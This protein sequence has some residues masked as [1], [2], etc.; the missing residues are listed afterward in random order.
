MA[1]DTS[2]RGE[3]PSNNTVVSSPIE[4]RFEAGNSNFK[5]GDL[6]ALSISLLDSE[7]LISDIEVHLNEVLLNNYSSF[8]FNLSI[9]TDSLISGRNTIRISAANAD[10]RLSKSASFNLFPVNSPDIYSYKV[11]AIY[12]HDKE[13][14]TQGLFYHNEFLYEGTG[15]YSRSGVRQVNLEDGKVLKHQGLDKKLFGEGIVFHDGYIYQLT[16]NSQVGIIYNADDLS[17]VRRYYYNG[18]GWGLTSDSS[19]LIRSDGSNKLYFHKPDDFSLIRTIEVYTEKGALN[20]LNELEYINGKIYANIYQRNQ[21]AIINPSNGIVEGLINMKGI[22]PKKY[23]TAQDDVLNGIAFDAV[24]NRLF[25]TGKYW[26]KLF[27]IEVVKKE[28]S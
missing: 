10:K 25:V 17:E 1:C 26:S 20:K 2:E 9:S 6:I 16:W 12:D 5:F 11:K 22:L 18:E 21:I 13:A 8:P 28:E 23:Q 24:N 15:Q 4:I 14:Y 3:R 7:M 19:Q 27:E